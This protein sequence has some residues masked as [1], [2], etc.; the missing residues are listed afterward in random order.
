MYFENT[1]KMHIDMSGKYTFKLVSN[2]CRAKLYD[3]SEKTVVL[4]YHSLTCIISVK[5][6]YFFITYAR[7]YML[8]I[9]RL[10]YKNTSFVTVKSL[11]FFCKNCQRIHLKK[12]RLHPRFT[13]NLPIFFRCLFL[14]KLVSSVNKEKLFLYALSEAQIQ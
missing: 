8:K 13:C 9:K 10:P 6:L 1:V 4:L 3:L 2:W 11:Y 14:S 7:K 5:I 12:T